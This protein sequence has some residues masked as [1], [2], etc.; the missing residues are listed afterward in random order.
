LEAGRHDTL[1][2]GSFSPCRGTSRF[3][4]IRQEDRPEVQQAG[5]GLRAAVRQEV[6]QIVAALQG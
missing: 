3:T 5:N 1:R 6:G 2:R 4:A